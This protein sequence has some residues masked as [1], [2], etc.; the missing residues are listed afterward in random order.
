MRVAKKQLR[1]MSLEEFGKLLTESI[2]GFTPKEKAEIRAAL[3]RKGDTTMSCVMGGGSTCE[4]CGG[5]RKLFRNREGLR[6][7]RCPLDE[8]EDILAYLR[9]D[10]GENSSRQFRANVRNEA[11][12][13]DPTTRSGA[14]R[15]DL[16]KF[17]LAVLPTAAPKPRRRGLSKKDRALLKS[18]A[19]KW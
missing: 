2:S 7:L 10:Y 6:I 9:L 19:V 11:E 17:V 3:L 15:E 18:L 16:K 8:A 14:S 1:G 12:L 4:K 13:S 5:R